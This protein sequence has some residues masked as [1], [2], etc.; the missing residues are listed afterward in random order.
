MAQKESNT[1]ECKGCEVH[2]VDNN[3]HRIF[4]SNDYRGS[5]VGTQYNE[6]HGEDKL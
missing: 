6:S 1:F 2:S 5:Q 3:M 4:F